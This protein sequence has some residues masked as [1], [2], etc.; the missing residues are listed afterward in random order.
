VLKPLSP[1][2]SLANGEAG[3]GNF[4]GVGGDLI[5]DPPAKG[6]GDGML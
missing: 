2:H 3:G 5:S 4:A 1:S 6:R